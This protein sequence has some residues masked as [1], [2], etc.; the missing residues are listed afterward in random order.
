MLENLRLPGSLFFILFVFIFSVS[1]QTGNAASNTEKSA[2]TPPIR[3]EISAKNRALP[4]EKTD[5][6]TAADNQTADTVNPYQL[7]RG[8]KNLELEYGISPFNPSNFAGPKEFN[9]YGRDLHLFTARL[10]RVIGTKRNVT[11]QYLFGVTPL[12]IFYKNEVTNPAYI[13]ATATPNAAPTKRDTTLAVAIQPVNFKF[14]FFARNRLKPYA[15]VGAGLLYAGK[16]VPVPYSK[17]FNLTGEFGGGVMY[18]LDAK[19]AVNFGYKY[20]HI[21]NGNIGGKINNP[22]FNANVFYVNYSFIWK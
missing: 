21:S 4:I 10:G 11:Y 1:G 5:S 22:G 16:P 2:E 15:Q 7:L 12:A 14:M 6:I 19:R 18:M 20:F 9:V 3:K 13:S 17:R 8:Q